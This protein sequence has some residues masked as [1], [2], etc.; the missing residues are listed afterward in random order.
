M[1]RIALPPEYYFSTAKKWAFLHGMRDEVASGIQN[2]HSLVTS[3]VWIVVFSRL[4]MTINCKTPPYLLHEQD[5]C[6]TRFETPTSK[7]KL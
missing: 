7:L 3:K 2:D 6:W 4:P 5:L 1:A